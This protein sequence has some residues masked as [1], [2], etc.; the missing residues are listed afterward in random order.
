MYAIRSYYVRTDGTIEGNINSKGKV[1]VGPNGT[2]NGEIHCVNCEIH[3][4]ITG[5]IVVKELLSLKETS[6]IHGE[7]KSGKLSIEPGA[8]FSG[9]CMMDPPAQLV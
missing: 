3:G 9:N 8:V 2:V 6:K 4:T 5:K 7:I 1:V